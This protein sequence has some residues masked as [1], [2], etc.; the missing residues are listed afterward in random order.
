[1]MKALVVWLTAVEFGFSG[2]THTELSLLWM[3]L[4][5]LLQSSCMEA[6]FEPCTHKKKKPNI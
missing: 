4:V 6:F 3:K 2:R 1:M 5:L